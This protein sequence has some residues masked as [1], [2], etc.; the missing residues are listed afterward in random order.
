M[1]SFA[2]F[3]APINIK[4]LKEVIPTLPAVCVRKADGKVVCTTFGDDKWLDEELKPYSG[5][6]CSKAEAIIDLYK[7]LKEKK[8]EVFE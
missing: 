1:R 8:P 4:G 3:E 7:V 5:E 2:D 6:G